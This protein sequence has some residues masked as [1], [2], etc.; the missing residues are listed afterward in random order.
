[1]SALARALRAESVK[2]RGTLALW[3][4]L[5]APALVVGLYVLQILTR[6]TGGAARTPPPP[7]EAWLMFAQSALGLWAF[8]MLPLLVT[9]QAAL[10]AGLEH[11]SQQWKHLL[12][13]P[14]PREVHYLAKLVALAA[15][16]LLSHLALAVLL[17]LGGLAVATLVPAFGL[18]GPPPWAWLAERLAWICA[19]TT[20][21]VALHTWIALHWRSFTV[22]VGVGMGATVAGFLIGQSAKY[23]PWYPWSLPVQVLASDP[24]VPSRVMAWSAAAGLV[25]ALAGLAAFVRRECP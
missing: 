19:A 15:M 11:G 6:F 5:V 23:G 1:M 21:L 24:A 17:P 9:L 7:A 2:L 3:M 22:A 4:C 10:L 14:L 8:L 12:A 20:L 13:L 25:V 16:V 18:S